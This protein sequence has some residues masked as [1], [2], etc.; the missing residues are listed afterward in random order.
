MR[1][2]HHTSLY[3][4]EIIFFSFLETFKINGALK[5][6][7]VRYNIWAPVKEDPVACLV[8]SLYVGH[9]FLLLCMSHL[10]FPGG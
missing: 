4:L 6:I 7:S 10:G 5:F 1:Q 8:E 9:T 2:Y 3:F